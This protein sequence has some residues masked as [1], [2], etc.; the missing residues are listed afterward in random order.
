MLVYLVA[1]PLLGAINSTDIENF[2]SMF[3]SLGFIARIFRIPLLLM[4]KICQFH[5]QKDSQQP[6]ED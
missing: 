1:A 4:E 5:W 6:I 2:K 3:S